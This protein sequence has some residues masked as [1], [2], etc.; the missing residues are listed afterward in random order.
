M[1][2]RRLVLGELLDEGRRHAEVEA[3]FTAKRVRCRGSAG[4]RVCRQCAQQPAAVESAQRAVGRGSAPLERTSSGR[5]S[6][7]TGR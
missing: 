2:E 1:I 4:Q 6:R 7:Q 5:T 3:L